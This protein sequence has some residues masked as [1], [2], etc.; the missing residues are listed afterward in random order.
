MQEQAVD[1]R[2]GGLSLACRPQEVL[3]QSTGRTPRGCSPF[4][5]E[6]FLRSPIR[7]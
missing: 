5:E 4:A 2:V 3:G 6:G 7:S 1:H